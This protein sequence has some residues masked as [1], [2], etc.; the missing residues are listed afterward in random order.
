[1]EHGAHPV[2]EEERYKQQKTEAVFLSTHEHEDEYTVSSNRSSFVD[3]W[4]RVSSSLLNT[5]QFIPILV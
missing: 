2:T 1:M 5:V 4:S 3:E